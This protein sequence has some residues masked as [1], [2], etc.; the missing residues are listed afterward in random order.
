MTLRRCRSATRIPPAKVSRAHS[1]KAFS[2]LES[3]SRSDASDGN[4]SY[5]L[6]DRQG[7]NETPQAGR[8]PIW[9]MAAKN[10]RNANRKTLPL[11]AFFEFFAATTL[12]QCRLEAVN[13]TVAWCAVHTQGTREG[14]AP[15]EPR[16]RGHVN[17]HSRLG[18]SLA[19]P[20]EANSESK[21]GP[22]S[23]YPSHAPR[24]GRICWKRAR[25]AIV[26]SAESQ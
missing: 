13:D 20:K 8:D 21:R 24:W 4:V 15:A 12:P 5:V 7:A 18:R 11:L 10:A 16:A 22:G 23:S 25:P 17:S 14:E 2:R 3:P 1:P 26:R 9:G 6:V 19:L